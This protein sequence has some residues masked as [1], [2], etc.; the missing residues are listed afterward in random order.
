MVAAMLAAAFA[1]LTAC[2][3]GSAPEATPHTT[4]APP[5]VE[6][7][8]PG[9]SDSVQTVLSLPLTVT[10]GNMGADYFAVENGL[11]YL[12]SGWQ[13]SVYE[14]GELVRTLISA[15]TSATSGAWTWTTAQSMS[16]IATGL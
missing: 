11:I 15:V 2:T 10:S 4:P 7:W 5:E 6:A 1:L 13:V 3:G 8:P 12:R 9:T 14:E 16:T